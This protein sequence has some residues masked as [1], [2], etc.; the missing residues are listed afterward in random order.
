[1]RD[2]SHILEFVDSYLFGVLTPGEEEYVVQHCAKCRICA[3]ALEEARKRVTALESLPAAEPSEELIHKSLKKVEIY[4]KGVPRR[5]R[6]KVLGIAAL[7]AFLVLPFALQI[8]FANLSPPPYDLRVMGQAQLVPG[9][10]AALRV[11]VV[12]P[13]K[14][15]GL[16]D[17]PVDIDLLD[18]KTDTTLHLTSFT[19]D[20]EGTG[21]PRF[22]LPEWSDGDYEIRVTARLGRTI[23]AVTQAIHLRQIPQNWKVMLSSD[24]PVYQPG[25]EIH[26]RA[27]ALRRLDL[28][29]LAAQKAIFVIRDPKENIIF[30]QTG[31]TSKF[32]IS[33]AD[34]PLA[35]EIGEG[36]YTIDC[37]LGDTSSKLPVE[38][39]RYVLPKFK[40][41]VTADQPYYQPGQRVTGKVKAQ[42]FF[43][44]PVAEGTVDLELFGKGNF[45]E[46]LRVKIDN[47][48][49]AVF[50]FPSLPPSVMDKDAVRTIE[51]HATVSDSAGQKQAKTIAL[52]VADQPLRIEVIPEGGAL[53][54]GLPNIIYLMV[55]TPDGQPTKAKLRV[56]PGNHELSVGELGVASFELTPEADEVWV[57]VQAEDG[58]GRTS[59][60]EVQLTCRAVS[61]DFIL[62]PEKAVYQGGDTINL[63]AIG[64]GNE[65]ILV[66]LV[67]DGQTM[68]TAAIPMAGGRG[69]TQLDLPVEVFGTVHL[70]G[71]RFPTTLRQ[72]RSLYVR[73][74][75]Q[76]AIRT[77][78]DKEEY[79]PGSRLRLGFQL[80]DQA[81]KPAAGALSLAGVDEAVFSVLDEVAAGGEEPFFII[82]PSLQGTWV[83]PEN[84]KTSKPA[85]ALEQDKLAQ[86][87][88]SRPVWN[89]ERIG[90]PTSLSSYAK[91]VGELNARKDYHLK[92]VKT[93]W[94]FYL[95]VVVCGCLAFL[96]HILLGWRKAA[97]VAVPG[98]LLVLFLAKGTGVEYIDR[99][100]Q[101]F[102]HQYEANNWTPP[103]FAF[104]NDQVFVS[105]PNMPAA[106]F[107]GWSTWAGQSF[108]GNMQALGGSG[109]GGAPPGG[110]DGNFGALRLP[111]MSFAQATPPR[112]RDWFP[113]TLL[114]RPELI[115]DDQGRASLEF[116]LA[117]SITT[118]RLTA[119]AVTAEG[120]LGATRESVK[121][122][123]PF[124]IDVN[125]PVALTRNDIVA[126]PV[127]LYNYL[128]KEQ[129]IELELNKAGWFELEGEPAQQVTLKPRE[130]KAVHYRLR[131][132]EVGLHH[133][134]VTAR[135]SG[136]SDAVGRRIEVVPDGVPVE[137]T[138]AGILHQPTQLDF[139]LPE[140]AIPGSGKLL[141]KIYPSVFSQLVEGLDG[142]FHMP[143]GCFEQTSSTTY[144]NVLALDYLKR[145]GKSVPAVETKARQ[146]IH[147]G[148]QRLLG[149]EVN[150]GGFDWFGRPPANRTLT[151]YGLMEFED[152]ARVHEVDPAL[153]ER[154]RKWLLD[155]RKK[156]GSW[157]PE[158]HV[159][160]NL[161][162][163]RLSGP[164]LA[165][166]ST[167]AYI[168]SAVYA[169]KSAAADIG[170]TRDFLLSHRPE[171]IHDPYVLALMSNALLSIESRGTTA[172]PY[173]ERL[174][175]LKRTSPDGKI[176]W[177]EQGDE[178]RTTFYGSGRSGSVETTALAALAFLQAGRHPGVTSAA[179]GW[180]VQ[181][182]DSSGTWGSTQATV[183]ALKALLAGTHRPLGDGERRIELVVNGEKQA[184]NIPADQAEVM[185]L[186][187]L[188]KG[189][190]AG[191]H[192]LRIAE[193]TGTG[194]GYQVVFCYHEPGER[195]RPGESLRIQVVYDKE[196]LKVGEAVQAKAT[197]EN[198][199]KQASPMVLVELPIPPGFTLNAED[200][201]RSVKANTM[202]KY[203][204]Q[205]RVVQVYL[206]DL[207]ASGK[208]EIGYA[209]RAE[210]A[211]RVAVPAG[212]AYEYYNPD[213]QGFSRTALLE[214]K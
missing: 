98:G 21:Q 49:A 112:L 66:D 133:L 213:R 58:Q 75:S 17:V 214:V 128:D 203:Q 178:N 9:T 51:I 42:Y 18:K 104:K 69:H 129:A 146:Y 89:E 175:A 155:Q 48:G 131:F 153:I 211:G 164:E 97:L 86:A 27:L 132:R 101:L 206:R 145:T 57:T 80:S 46:R 44:K 37:E 205:P 95:V 74:A 190:V 76:L 120:K 73:P 92:Y 107:G 56:T 116:D 22:R 139:T 85:Q 24:R 67:K 83:I 36:T 207:P 172:L 3:V 122:F 8:Y 136:I 90:E 62:R 154:T 157:D 77:K 93:L 115:T 6:I 192:S 68:L 2:Y 88:F 91:R 134:Q 96:G 123:Q 59:R 54:R 138:F 194:A 114:W 26:I 127:V 162:G 82:D 55:R 202:A 14:G 63:A 38:V 196:N 11:Q 181:Q 142:I 87:I 50:E 169:N 204:V 20:S 137:K 33:S 105:E 140:N 151:A 161:P 29:P 94:L 34:C 195:T 199:R 103:D 41:E 159:P 35:S 189:L 201:D 143:Y 45:K 119:S 167:T 7:V 71:V 25:Q 135:G 158:G 39:K 4:E 16:K 193:T 150:G 12:E 70:V 53:V 174:A 52:A 113:E 106:G 188:S 147:L 177:W 117:D 184:L 10:T 84:R 148:Y 171:S 79:R 170:P 212:R 168:A 191:T 166:L 165:R 183:L 108:A 198:R 28:K 99:F 64:G 187:D 163:G 13:E 15:T 110:F 125:L 60:R 126:V 149:F 47:Q 179:L 173:L 182:K 40:I 176:T 30:K 156:D 100:L 152:M 102:E 124:F 61:G 72:V 121:V 141:V 186:V 81:G 209:L 160:A 19:T 23:E 200:F 109:W 5:R 111:R 144:P 185:K 1:M 210:L 130:V 208:L 78:A 180:L 32:G 43:G 197:L 31:K 118:W 65:P